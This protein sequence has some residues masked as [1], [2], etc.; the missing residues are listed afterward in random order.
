MAAPMTWQERAA[1]H[2]RRA[3][4]LLA[5]H[6]ERRQAGLAHPVFDFLFT[7]YRLRPRHLRVW[8]PGYGV[9][10][11]GP[12]ARDYLTRAGY[13][14]HGGGVAV[15]RDHLVARSDT[16]GFIADLL[17]A[18]ASRPPRFGCFG[19]HEWA[20]V[21]RT[22][23]VRHGAVP[24][25]LGA[26]GTDAVVES[27]PLRCSHFDAYRFFTTAAAPRNARPLSRATQIA[28]EQPGCVHAG[29]DLYK[30]AAKLGPL[31]ESS[32][33]LDCF[34]LAVDARVL[35]MRASPYDLRDFGL[36]PIPVETS[37]GRAQ[38]AAA[39]E[40]ISVRAAPLRARLIDACDALAA[41]ADNGAALTGTGGVFTGGYAGSTEF[42]T[43][44][45][46]SSARMPP[47]EDS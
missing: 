43:G 3:D 8:H 45:A 29:M 47:R 42:T 41:S 36:A 4:A 18:T 46:G 20:M 13:H 31:I 32:L 12:G 34:A 15:S 7:Y 10:L 37:A 35:D 2:R 33:L 24:L 44:S 19:M 17:T 1:A 39:Q 22:S 11:T 27:M 38:Y 25:R 14:R 40:A 21:Y 28:E 9:V 30:W 23:E 6:V 5:P 16:V 26:A